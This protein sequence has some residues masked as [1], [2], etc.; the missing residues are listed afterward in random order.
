MNG[1]PFGPGGKQGR[2]AIQ[3]QYVQKTTE[4]KEKAA[5][6]TGEKLT[7]E[8]IRRNLDKMGFKRRGERGK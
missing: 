5:A 8:V 7:R 3:S 6:H 2:R 1:A 4:K